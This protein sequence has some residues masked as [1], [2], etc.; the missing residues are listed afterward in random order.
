MKKFLIICAIMVL[1]VSSIAGAVTVR[2]GGEK[3]TTDF[4]HTIFVEYASTTTCPYCPAASQDMYS[5]YQSGEYPFYYVSLISDQN[6]IAKRR[7]NFMHVYYIPTVYFDGGFQ[8]VTGAVGDQPYKDALDAAGERDLKGT[9]DMESSAT[10]LGDAKFEV[11]VTVTNSGNKPYFGILRSYTTEIQSR[12]ND[13]DGV[14]YHYGFLDFALS[15][16]VLIMPGK[17][18][19]VTGTF[20]GNADH[21]GQTYEDI[22]VDNLFVVSAAF[23]WLPVKITSDQDKTF[24]A[25]LPDQ[26]SATLV[27]Q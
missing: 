4:N 11:S 15:K 12:W 17:S 25:F 10:W 13:A 7:M 5:V 2:D 22:T 19:T 18:K 9:L 20:D 1:M 3:Q 23:H 24:F 21:G 26:C 27:E 16:L 14:P 6:N 8:T